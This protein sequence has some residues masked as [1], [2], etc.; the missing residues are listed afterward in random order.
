MRVKNYVENRHLNSNL[1]EK[2]KEVLWKYLFAYERQTV[3]H[4]FMVEKQ[5]FLKI[6][7]MQ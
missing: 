4:N 5:I 1:L 2:I 7:E 6:V 3:Y